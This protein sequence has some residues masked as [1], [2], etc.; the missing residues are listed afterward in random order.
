[1]LLVLSAFTTILL[2]G[3][4]DPSYV[5]VASL[6]ASITSQSGVKF[7]AGPDQG[8]DGTT[9]SVWGLAVPNIDCYY[10]KKESTDYRGTVNT[11][12]Q[13]HICQ[14]WSA[15]SPNSHKN[16]PE[17]K[18]NK[19]LEGNNYCRDPDGEY[20][21][22]CYTVDGSRW[23]YC[24]I[25]LCYREP[26]I[27][28]ITGDGSEYRG[29]DN[30][31]KNGKRCQAWDSQTPNSHS[32]SPDEFPE[33]GLEYNSY[34]RNPDNEGYLW[35]YT[36]D[37]PRWEKCATPAC[38]VVESDNAT[39]W[40]AGPDKATDGNINTVWD[41]GGCAYTDSDFLN[42]W[43][44][45]LDKSYNIDH[46]V[47][48]GL[49][50]AWANDEGLLDG[51]K[52]LIGN[53]ICAVISGMRTKSS[54]GHVFNCAGEPDMSQG[55]VVRLENMG[56]R[57]VLCE[58]QIMVRE[59]ALAEEPPTV[60]PSTSDGQEIGEYFN[61][62]FKKV[63][64]TSS[65]KWE[66]SS[67]RA[68]DGWVDQYWDSSSCSHTNNSE[69]FQFWKVDLGRTYK[70]DHILIYNRND[71]SSNRLEGAMLFVDGNVC[72]RLTDTGKEGGCVESIKCDEDL[73]AGRN[74]TISLWNGYLSLCEVQVMVKKVNM[75]LAPT[76]VSWPG[77]RVGNFTN[78]ALDFPLFRETGTANQSSTYK[79]YKAGLANDGITDGDAYSGS[80]THTEQT[81]H[82]WWEVDLKK[83]Y[84]IHHIT[85]YGR[86]DKYS[87]RIEG[88]RVMAGQT[89]VGDNLKKPVNPADP[90]IVYPKGDVYASKVLVELYD[91]Y[92]S[93]AEVQV[94][95]ANEE[96]F[97]TETPPALKWGNIA[98][99]RP[100]EQSS[101]YKGRIADRGVDNF[102][103]SYLHC[104]HTLKEG[105]NWWQV[106][107]EREYY[108]DH[109]V[110]LG[111][112]DGSQE[113]I[114]R[115]TLEIDGRTVAGFSYTLL[116][117]KWEFPLHGYKGRV[118]RIAKKNE[119]LT[120]C[121]VQVMVNHEYEPVDK[122]EPINR[123]LLDL[124]TTAKVSAKSVL[125]GTG[126]HLVND[127]N[128]D[129]DYFRNSC[130]LSGPAQNQNW[131]KLELDEEASISNVTIYPRLDF[132]AWEN[133]EGAE[134][135]VDK[136]LCGTIKY[137]SGILFY[138]LDCNGAKGSRV[139]VSKPGY[140][141]VCEVV[142]NPLQTAEI[143]IMQ[144][145]L[146]FLRNVV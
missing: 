45:T 53:Q 112:T 101:T 95:V 143:T 119:Y 20:T 7:S 107:L 123:G 62:A 135:R 22:W 116:Q 17:S 142:I 48:Y 109:I 136:H 91:K 32:R 117:S 40:T 69:Q 30:K 99:R 139:T 14:S 138:E 114:E 81:G 102:F 145:I 140:L 89:Q 37:G 121:D 127:G 6:A 12:A 41:Q 70:I 83:V 111:R 86:S 46:V 110:V 128:T 57:M 73:M 11:T 60:D 10:G 31:T 98:L 59:D 113:R 29:K 34:C 42:W 21:P 55:Q 92:L 129:A 93:L 97:P 52:I 87:E 23:E 133:I 3:N 134:V 47:I 27:D 80:V 58:V 50:D 118:V 122:D 36:V 131:L 72:T 77:E 94:W 65:M 68:V 96:V 115:A 76:V 141:S 84:K 82:Q 15:Q 24:D 8:A 78:V 71:F 49:S 108:I 13:G 104:T 16:T 132:N 75:E 28:C 33:G 66:G 120:L 79:W 61:V 39:R 88:S 51:A 54:E 26:N 2:S 144:R 64:S 5:N 4:A 38:L 19:G 126:P 106:D 130:Y 56:R 63:T 90:M 9:G 137:I 43:Q 124:A 18:P 74:I 67:S 85:V 35:C 146:K 1:M 44:I 103:D 100:A 125:F 25:P 105:V